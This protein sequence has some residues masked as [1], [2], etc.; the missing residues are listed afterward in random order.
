[1]ET[2]IFEQQRTAPKQIKVI[3]KI[4]MMCQTEPGEPCIQAGESAK[5]LVV[6]HKRGD[7]TGDKK[8]KASVV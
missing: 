4:E 7:W 8:W 5:T 6:V 2:V 1:M 3:D